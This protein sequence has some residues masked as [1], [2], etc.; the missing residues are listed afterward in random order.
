MHTVS[1]P[2]NPAVIDSGTIGA[3][4]APKTVPIPVPEVAAARGPMHSVFWRIFFWFW[5][6][7][8]LLAV[9]VAATVY[10]TDP[11]QFFP[12][13]RYVPLQR[14][15]QLAATSVAMME[16][17]GPTA[18]HNYLTHLPRSADSAQLTTRT[19]FDRAYLFD[20]DSGHELSGQPL[21]T[22][23]R[24]LVSRAR[25]SADLQLE[26]LLTEALMA[27]AVRNAN[28]M[29]AYVFMLAMPR[30]SPWLP[31][32]P[33]FWWQIAAALATSALVCY[34][35]ARN[36]VAPVRRLQTAARRLAGGDLGT[37]VASTPAFSNRQ[38]E[39]S[40]LAHD[41]DEMAA[42]IEGLLTAQRRLIADI[43]HELGSPLTRVN[44]ALGLAFRKAGD[45]VRP[46]LERIEREAHRVNEL[47]RQLLLLSELENRAASGP[48][49]TVDLAAV[50]HEV[51]A[52]AEFEA[53]GRRCRVRVT[54][55]EGGYDRE[56]PLCLLGVRHLLHS[57]IENVVRNAVRYTAEDSEVAIELE[58][59]APHSDPE[60]RGSAII[61]VRDHGPG[62]PPSSLAD[63]FLPFYRVSEARDRQ[64]GGTGLG[65]AITRQAVLAHGGTVHATNHPEGGLVVEIAL[66]TE[67][68]SKIAQTSPIQANYSEG[69]AKAG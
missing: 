4:R 46:E 30:P 22:D 48:L 54:G 28:G 17:K 44:V 45:A 13:W 1:P 37:R 58:L 21:P 49:E 39:F 61:R 36:V 29:H 20:A 56:N 53:S 24:E 66:S 16:E 41:F 57:A 67:G 55:R 38:D 18:L 69:I 3:G 19:R 14:I 10:I 23:T 42:R 32:T 26:R 34:W 52:D 11:D 63:L 50:V 5:L 65:L 33:Q 9:A 62:V 27:R 59:L 15:D 43:S 31:T 51:A 12:H 68:R 8:L 64:S 47:V 40:D 60:A 7:M 6:A 25:G 35:L 2:T